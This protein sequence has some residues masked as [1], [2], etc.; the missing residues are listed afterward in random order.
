MG[1]F[2]AILSPAIFGVTN[3]VDKFLLEKDNISPIVITVFGG[4]FAFV[5]GLII[6][7]VTGFYPIDLKTLIIILASGYLT[8]IYLLPYYKALSLDDASTI[9]PLLQTYPVFV[10][11][12]SYLMLGENLTIKGYIG[13]SL[14]IVASFALSLEKLKFG[15]FKFRKSFFFIILSSFLFALA[16]VL[17]KFGVTEVPFWNTLPYEG[18]GIALGA[19]SVLFYKNNINKI[20]KETSKLSKRAYSLMGLN[21]AIYILARYTGYFA[22][23]LISVGLVSVL[24]GFQSLFGLI[25]GIILSIKFPYILRE[26]ITKKTL[27]LKITSIILIII[28]SYFIFSK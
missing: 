25:Y 7:L 16:Q 26:V 5:A 4:I 8:S 20:K 21:E 13:S 1:I 12:L 9:I 6:L 14:I 19:L 23:S 18:F 10:L 27:G 28:G 11:I 2:F 22:I 15:I 3:Y 24:A 17:Y